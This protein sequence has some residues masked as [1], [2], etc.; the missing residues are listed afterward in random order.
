M[1]LPALELH[2]R[3]DEPRARVT[4]R[5]AR[6][7]PS[8]ARTTSSRA[9][10]AV[11]DDVDELDVT[12]VAEL[13]ARGRESGELTRGE[14]QDAL[15]TADVGVE[16]L[17]ALIAR[18]VAV[19]VEIVEDEA[20]DGVVAAPRRTTA[21]HAGTADLVR[22]YLREIGKVPLLNAAQ[23]V[24]LSKRVEAGLFAEFKLDSEPD[25]ARGA[26]RGARR[27]GP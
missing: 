25:L 24:E 23:E 11:A 9:L 3:T 22:M 21:E 5:R 17:P 8:P 12:A 2:E 18:L 15:E 6:R 27:P 26:P 19:G 14:L 7:T 16:L 1:T 20:A 4:T 10:T 13:I